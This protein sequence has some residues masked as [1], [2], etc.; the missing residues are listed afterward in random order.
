MERL[1][2][3]IV[4]LLLLPCVTCFLTPSLLVSSLKKSSSAFD[5]NINKAKFSS[6]GLEH[7]HE[8]QFPYLLAN[9]AKHTHLYAR[10]PKQR[11]SFSMSNYRNNELFTPTNILLAINLIVFLITEKYPQLKMKFMKI[12]WKISRGEEY[13]LLTSIFL[14]GSFGHLMTNSYSLHNT[15]NNVSPFLMSNRLY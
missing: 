14:H 11:T 2:V 7:F 5:Q 13:R 8:E 12:N 1:I 6:G 15:G 10:F 4:A 3:V 9:P